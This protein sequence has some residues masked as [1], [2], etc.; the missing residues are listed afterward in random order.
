M[1]V[2]T[3][4]E[5]CTTDRAHHVKKWLIIKGQLIK[6]NPI[7]SPTFL[8]Y[9]WSK[10]N[11]RQ[12][13]LGNNIALT[14]KCCVFYR[15]NDESDRERLL[16]INTADSSQDLHQP[17]SDFQIRNRYLSRIGANV[18]LTVFNTEYEKL[19]PWPPL[20]PE[21]D[22][23]S[24]TSPSDSTVMNCSSQSNQ[25]CHYIV[26]WYLYIFYMD[27]LYFMYTFNKNNVSLMVFLIMFILY[28]SNINMTF[29]LEWELAN[30]NK[31]VTSMKLVF[32]LYQLIIFILK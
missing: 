18:S 28:R 9:F 1:L 7:S 12:I 15:A 31:P 8:E 21:I 3:S 6:E 13:K 11:L 5:C 23:P 2:C 10:T 16:S 20:L 4:D 17:P 26:L 25:S 29:I 24:V 14:K 19:A 27:I 32:Q 30:L 22:A